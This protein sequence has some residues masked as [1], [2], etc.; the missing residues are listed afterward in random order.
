MNKLIDRHKISP[1][2]WVPRA[3]LASGSPFIPIMTLSI[4]LY[5]QLGLSNNLIYRLAISAMGIKAL[6]R[7]SY[8]PNKK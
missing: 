3:Y 8:R 5:K 7:I 4:V 6:S 2:N 1:W